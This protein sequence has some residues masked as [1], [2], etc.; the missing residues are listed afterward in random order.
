MRNRD[1][2]WLTFVK[3]S[4]LIV[5]ALTLLTKTPEVYGISEV[6]AHWIGFVATVITAL[7]ATKQT[8]SWP[9]ENDDKRIDR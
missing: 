1:A 8:S 4:G 9:G 2:W 3:Y 7:A 6:W 5:A